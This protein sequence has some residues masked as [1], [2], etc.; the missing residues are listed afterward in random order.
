M[1]LGKVLEV[2]FGGGLVHHDITYPRIDKRNSAAGLGIAP[3]SPRRASAQGSR[4]Y[5]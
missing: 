1:E 3:I 2:T 5:Q 4:R